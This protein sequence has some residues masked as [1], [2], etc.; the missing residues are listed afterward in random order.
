MLTLTQA[1]DRLGLAPSTLRWQVHRGKLKGRLLGKMW[2]VSEREVERYRA[3]SLGR[4]RGTAPTTLGRL[5]TF[6]YG[7]LRSIDQV[8][9]LLDD[10]GVDLVVDVRLVPKSRL[11]LWGRATRDTILSAGRRYIWEPELGNL[12]YKAGGI[13]IAD[14]DAVETVLDHLRA[15]VNV[16]LM[17]VC[18]SADD[19]HRSTVAAEA[20]LRE[21]RLEIEHVVT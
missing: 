17:C 5:L 8:R 14:L 11:P 19:C 7:R 2:I 9:A 3:E 1:A 6:G 4:G 18:S 15:G 12:D 20:G 13:R 10:A 16:A 21:P